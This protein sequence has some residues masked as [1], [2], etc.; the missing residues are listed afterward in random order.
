MPREQSIA[1]AGVAVG[2]PLSS[3]GFPSVGFPSVGFP[4]V[5]LPRMV[6]IRH[7]AAV[8]KIPTISPAASRRT[9]ASRLPAGPPTGKSVQ[10]ETFV[11]TRDVRLFR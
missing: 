9:A 8:R 3:V 7:A 1:F 10:I 4:S 11:A 6:G 2:R 5:G